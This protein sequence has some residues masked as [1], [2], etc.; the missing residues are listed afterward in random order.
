MELDMKKALVILSLLALTA[1]LLSTTTALAQA[2][3]KLSLRLSRTFGFSS[4]TGDIQ[5]TFKLTATGPDNLVKVGFYMDDQTLGELTQSPFALSFATDSYPNGLHTLRAVGTTA[6]GVELASNEIRANFV[7]ASQGFKTAGRILIPLFIL[8]FV[9]MLSSFFF[10]VLLRRG[11]LEELAPGTP[12]NYGFKGGAVCPRCQRPFVLHLISLNL[13]FRRK[14]ERCPYCG[15]MGVVKA[16]TLSELRAA[17][18]AELEQAHLA[19]P[20]A[21]ETEDEKLR[22]E[23]EKSRYRDV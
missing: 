22:K 7:P 4:G 2:A 6:D 11:K 19:Q 15:R 17:E 23:L 16:A 1:G 20:V 9:L 3:D 8:I 21:E 5:G 12:R 18:S 14:F 13:G 10:P